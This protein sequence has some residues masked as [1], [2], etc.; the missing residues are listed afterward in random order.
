MPEL[1][2]PA[3]PIRQ[4][5]AWRE[6]AEGHRLLQRLLRALIRA[7]FSVEPAPESSAALATADASGRPAVRMVLVKEAG[8]QGFVFYTNYESSKAEDLL[9]NPRAALV[10]HW[11]HFLR[12]VRVEGMVERL[13]EEENQAYFHTRPRESQLAAWAS[14]QSR[15]LG[16]PELLTRRVEEVRQRYRGREVPCP[17]FWGGYRVR[18]ERIEFWQGRPNRLH[19]RRCYVREGESWRSFRLM[20]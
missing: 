19:D 9:A 16:T 7:A 1:T 2:S 13:T 20:P 6:Q 12:Q 5:S 17:E 18:P 10:F 8:P 11:P 3:D 14:Q 4:F 15:E